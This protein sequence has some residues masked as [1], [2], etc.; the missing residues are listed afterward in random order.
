MTFLQR[1]LTVKARVHILLC[2]LGE[3]HCHGVV[4]IAEIWLGRK[5]E[6]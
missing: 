5:L 3:N 1:V 2:S 4:C 6:L